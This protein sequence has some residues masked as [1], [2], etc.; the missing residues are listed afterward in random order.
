MSYHLKDE[1]EDVSTNSSSVIYE[2]TFQVSVFSNNGKKFVGCATG[3]IYTTPQTKSPFLKYTKARG[4]AAATVETEGER[5]LRDARR[6]A[7]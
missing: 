6:F 5:A 7:D 2:K 3:R 4:Q 1:T